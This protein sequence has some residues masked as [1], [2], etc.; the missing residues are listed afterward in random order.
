MKCLLN[1]FIILVI[2]DVFVVIIVI[3]K[4]AKE[5]TKEIEKKA[6]IDIYH[7]NEFSQHKNNKT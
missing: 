5:G 1:G 7:I 3:D 6:T 4:L 2:I